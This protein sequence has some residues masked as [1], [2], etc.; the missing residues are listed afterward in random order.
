V[1]PEMKRV[2]SIAGLALLGLAVAVGISFA[3]SSLSS[4]SIGISEEPLSAGQ[5]LAPARTVTAPAARRPTQRARTQTT[6]RGTPS[7]AAAP[8]PPP[9]PPPVAA[10]PPPPPAVSDDNSGEDDSG[11]GR[12]RGRGRGG[13]DSSGSG[14]D[15]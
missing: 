15:D 11:R 13:D 12:G 9:P 8:P 10:A 4:Q 1:R 6:P 3:A 14:S 2:L 7:P 5:E